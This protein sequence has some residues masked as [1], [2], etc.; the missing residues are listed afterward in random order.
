MFFLVIGILWYIAGITRYHVVLKNS[1]TAIGTQL[2]F[3]RSQAN[4]N[5]KNIY[6]DDQK[7]VM[8]VQLAVADESTTMLPSKGTSYTVYAGSKSLSASHLKQIT[9]LFGRMSTSGDMILILPHPQHEVYSFFIMNNQ[10]L[11]FDS[12]TAEMVNDGQDGDSSDGG[13]NADATSGD[14]DAGDDT[15]DDNAA[16]SSTKMTSEQKKNAVASQMAQ[17]MNNY[18]Y[19]DAVNNSNS[20]ATNG[21][22]AYTIK[23]NTQDI[24]SFRVTNYPAIH[25]AAYEP[26]VIH[27]NLIKSN[28]EFDFKTFYDV[29]YKQSAINHLKQQSSQLQDQLNQ[30]KTV[31]SE[32]SSRLNVNPDDQQ[33]ATR[34]SQIKSSES[35]LAEQQ[36][37]IQA[38][39]KK[40]RKNQFDPSLFTNL[41][42]RARVVQ[43][44]KN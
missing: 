14:P 15:I 26:K 39:I 20:N 25:T 10:Y 37:E 42:T 33:A 9:V 19:Q 29:V 11:G 16:T 17:A 18:N 1:S 4:V 38:K 22:N 30:I 2:Q 40:Y 32:I 12:N 21:N 7:N 34:M 5:I 44:L 35:S 36:L 31:K 28:N 3:P 13:Q 6:T 27:H 41:Q 8:I 24:I 23:S 43:N